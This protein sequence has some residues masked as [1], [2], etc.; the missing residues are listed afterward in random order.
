MD[1][2]LYRKTKISGPLSGRSQILN[3]AKELRLKAN[4]VEEA[5]YKFMQDAIE[6][7]AQAREIEQGSALNDASKDGFK[8]EKDDAH[9]LRSAGERFIA[10]A[11]ENGAFFKDM[12]SGKRFGLEE[13][14][15]Y[16]IGLAIFENELILGNKKYADLIAKSYKISDEDKRI[17]IESVKSR[18]SNNRSNGA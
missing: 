4:D 14:V 7:R 6:L 2:D 10:E 9:E 18:E 12:K 13:D 16:R 5:A 3:A 8:F 1:N 15:F 11:I 17:A